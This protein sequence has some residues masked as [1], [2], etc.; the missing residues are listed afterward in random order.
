MWDE[1]S[2]GGGFVVVVCG[3]FVVVVGETVEG[4]RGV[5]VGGGARTRD[6]A[7]ETGQG[8]RVDRFRVVGFF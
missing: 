3:G 8:R 1:C 5:D 6:D 7:D 2:D 4:R